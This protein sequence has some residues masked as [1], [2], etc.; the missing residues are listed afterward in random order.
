MAKKSLQDINPLEYDLSIP[1]SVSPEQKADRLISLGKGVYKDKI[2]NK[3]LYNYDEMP[4][5]E[6][7]RRKERSINDNLQRAYAKGIPSGTM[8]ADMETMNAVTGGA[9]NWT[10]PSQ[11]IGATGRLIKNGDFGQFGRNLILGNNGIVSDAYTAKHPYLSM[12][13]NTI[14][15]GIILGLAG[16]GKTGIK[17]STNYIKQGS[18]K[19]KTFYKRC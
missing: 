2:S 11:V 1:V 13:V 18:K 6:I 15:D 8:S 3:L 12:A 9:L 19:H 4:T 5:A 17:N 16:A 7:V 14:G 10:M